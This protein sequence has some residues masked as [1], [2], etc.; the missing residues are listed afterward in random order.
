[1]RGRP[2]APR[3]GTRL[4]PGG[5]RLARTRRR[6]RRR[7]LWL[8]VKDWRD[9]FASHARH[10]HLAARDPPPRSRRCA[11]AGALEH[12]PGRSRPRRRWRSAA[13]NLASA[14]TPNV[15]W[16]G[17]C[18]SR[19]SR[20]SALPVFHTLAVPASVALIVCA[21]YLGRRRRRAWQA[22][23]ALLVVLGALDLLKGLDFEEAA[24]CWRSRPRCSGGAR[25]AFYVRHDRPDAPRPPWRALAI[26]GGAYAVDR[27]GRR[28]GRR[29][30]S[31]RADRRARPPTCCSGR[32]AD[33]LRR[34][35]RLAAARRRRARP[36]WRSLALAYLLFRPL[37]APAPASRPRPRRAAGELVRAHG[38]G[39]ALRSSSSAATR[40]YL[41]ASDRRAFVG[42]RDR[43]R[44]AARLRR[45]GRRPPARSRPAPRALRASP[46]VTACG[47][48]S[49][50]AGAAAA[51]AL[52][53]GRPARASTSA[54]R[55]SS[56]P[57]AFS[58]EGR[59][60]RKVRQSVI[61]ARRAPATRRERA[62]LGAAR[63][64]RRRASSS[65]SPSGW[66]D[67]AP[68]R[69]F[70]MAMDSLDA[71]SAGQRRRRRAGRRRARSAASSTSCP[72]YGRA[73]MSLSFMRRDHDTPNGLTE[74][75]VVQAIE[76]LRERG[77][78][79]ALAELRGLRPPDPQPA[80]TA[81]PRARAARALANPFFQIESLYRF[82]AKFDPRWEPRYLV[83]RGRARPAARR[84]RG[85][86]RRGPAAQL[87]VALA[88]N[89]Q[90]DVLDRPGGRLELT[91]CKLRRDL[92][93]KRSCLA[94]MLRLEHRLDRRLDFVADD[95]VERD[96]VVLAPLDVR[97][98]EHR[99]RWPRRYPSR[100]SAPCR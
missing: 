27:A 60:I 85:H 58:L 43:E 3:R 74:F 7:R 18:C 64:P 86:A 57:R 15:A 81:R 11:T 44:R 72:R 82:N 28:G 17:H 24:L 53:R 6:A 16:R 76:L 12:L 92:E 95:Q 22:A 89:R 59:A 63:P 52:A 56:R 23:L 55:R 26:A 14:L 30:T 1:M 45:P 91:G 31:R 36:L 32:R 49:V 50:G 51:A 73:A 77:R 68:E 21:F 33:R 4:R 34:R 65:A 99:R 13:V 5:D 38:R 94:H 66:R 87:P 90:R 70:S 83:L 100:R 47:S 9:L 54:T 78:R 96:R 10:G 67:G 40:S 46:S 98:V 39:H 80:R 75:L 42:Y 93:G 97:V 62:E 2:G 84:P 35:P 61:A 79:G 29:P 88:G 71:T 37:A 20:S 19:S 69:G 41:F 48:A 8:V 25:D